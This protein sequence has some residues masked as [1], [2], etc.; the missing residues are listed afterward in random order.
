MNRVPESGNQL[1]DSETAW[2]NVGL[3]LAIIQI[4]FLDVSYS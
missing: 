1:P 2:W 3:Y 4:P